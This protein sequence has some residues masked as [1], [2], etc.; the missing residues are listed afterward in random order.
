M[1]PIPCPFCGGTKIVKQS[2]RVNG[3]YGKWLHCD[4]CGANG[5]M[6]VADNQ[7]KY[8]H[9]IA[10]NKRDGIIEQELSMF[11]YTFFDTSGKVLAKRYLVD[12]QEA[13][14]DCQVMANTYH[15]SVHCYVSIC[16]AHPE[17]PKEQEHVEQSTQ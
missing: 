7:G 17:Y 6:I 12:A 15:I 8:D 4:T 13:K 10:W 11:V 2:C 5:P 3:G 1:L 14:A 16:K 9:I